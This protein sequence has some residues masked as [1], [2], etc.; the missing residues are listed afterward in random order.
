MQSAAMSKLSL[1]C[2]GYIPGRKV[3]AIFGP[4]NPRRTGPYRQIENVL[5]LDLPCVPCLATHCRLEA[6]PL[7]C[8]RG[9]R[10]DVVVE[11]AVG[12]L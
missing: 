7:E 2:S 8:L 6:S 1:T 11:R 4:T 3:L 9:I 12:M 5:Q 10:P